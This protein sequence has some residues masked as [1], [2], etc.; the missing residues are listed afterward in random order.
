MNIV[1][2]VEGDPIANKLV[3]ASAIGDI[4]TVGRLISKGVSPSATDNHWGETALHVACEAGHKST[5]AYL[6]E[7]GAPLNAHNSNGMTPLMTACSAGRNEIV[8]ALVEAGADVMYARPEDSMTA[9]KFALWGRCSKG[10]IKQLLASGAIEPEPGFVVVHLDTPQSD[11]WRRA[12]IWA[13]RAFIAIGLSALLVVVVVI[14][15][16]AA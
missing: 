9:L 5:V 12:K 8:R 6:V 13:T 10:V 16:G 1:Y 4:E 15:R 11:G 2:W 14:R 7:K 3:A